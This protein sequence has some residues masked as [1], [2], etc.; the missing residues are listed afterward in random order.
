MFEYIEQNKEWIFSGVGVLAIS[1]LAAL[2]WR[3]IN[4]RTNLPTPQITVMQVT[5]IAQAN[6]KKSP[7]PALSSGGMTVS[8][9]APITRITPITLDEIRKAVDSAPPLQKAQ[10]AKNYEGL[11]IEWNSQLSNAEMKGDDA[12]WLILLI[13]EPIGNVIHCTVKLSEYKELGILNKGAPIRVTGRIKKVTDISLELR[14]LRGQFSHCCVLHN[15]WG[16][17]AYRA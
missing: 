13:G 6:E 17:I 15:V 2:I 14:S 4:A 8:T 16:R 9:P 10:I 1:T 11:H 7:E 12:V 3:T 5:Q